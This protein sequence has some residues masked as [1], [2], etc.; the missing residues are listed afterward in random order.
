M[1]DDPELQ[2][3]KK[4]TELSSQAHYK[5]KNAIAQSK[6]RP[7]DQNNGESPKIEEKVAAP[8]INEEEKHVVEQTLQEVENVEQGIG[9]YGP[10]ANDQQ[11]QEQYEQ[12]SYPD[13][14]NAQTYDDSN[15]DVEQDNTYETPPYD[16][17]Q[18]QGYS[19]NTDIETRSDYNQ[20]LS[21]DDAREQQTADDIYDIPANDNPAAEDEY[22]E[23]NEDGGNLD[24]FYATLN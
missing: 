6:R 8:V 24:D 3:L 16:Q 11:Q 5:G 12:E 22:E 2:R 20:Y 21:E 10:G 18:T 17:D 9:D 23:F 19:E 1:A 13:A 14:D 15:E 7:R 4:M